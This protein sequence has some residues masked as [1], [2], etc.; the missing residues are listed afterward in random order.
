MSRLLKHDWAGYATWKRLE[1]K[2]WPQLRGLTGL[3]DHLSCKPD[4]IK[5]RDGF[6]R[7]AGINPPKR[8]ILPTQGP[9]RPCKQ[10]LTR[11][12]SC[13]RFTYFQHTAVFCLISKRDCHAGHWL[14]MHSTI[15]QHTA[16]IHSRGAEDMPS[17]K[18][19]GGLAATRIGPVPLIRLV[20]PKAMFPKARWRHPVLGLM[21]ILFGSLLEEVVT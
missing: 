13:N 17:T 1:G 4:H 10:A 20:Q 11:T 8:V 9:P 14:A 21:E 15:S 2:I 12:S 19:I 16:I 7:P 3:A 5:I 6:Y 18:G